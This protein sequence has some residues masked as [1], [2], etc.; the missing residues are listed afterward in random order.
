MGLIENQEY[1]PHIWIEYWTK[2]YGHLKDT[3]K[4]CDKIQYLFM[5]KNSQQTW[6]KRELPQSDKGYLQ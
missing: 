4:A 2:H 6:N 1:K 5:I 3:G